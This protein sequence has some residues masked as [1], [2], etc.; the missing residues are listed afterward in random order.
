[1][2]TTRKL[3]AQSRNGSLIVH[4]AKDGQLRVDATVKSRSEGRAKDAAIQIEESAARGVQ[5]SI[6][7]PD[8]EWHEGD[9]ADL[10]IW[11]PEAVGLDL[12][13]SNGEIEAAGFSGKC[14]ATTSNADVQISD[15]AGDLIAKSSNGDIVVTRLT[16]SADAATSNSGIT[17]NDVS[18]P[19]TAA[20]SN[21]DIAIS[22]ASGASGPVKAHTS[23]SSITLT[24]G[25]AFT[26]S[27]SA[28]TSNG[29]V[30][31]LVSRASR[32]TGNTSNATFNFGAGTTSSLVT[33]NG[34]VTV[35]SK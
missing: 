14:I 22:L 23:N 19:V 35:K 10:E 7:W 4:R 34:N 12:T 29:H 33:S 15:H 25:A 17:M 9:G 21:G 28:A 8:K 32:S 24:V 18:G 1:M 2:R 6:A 13:T 20:T 26:G 5:V 31:C 11:I 16:G 3:A 27:V 30:D